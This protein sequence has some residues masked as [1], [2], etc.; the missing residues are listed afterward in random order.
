[1]E[2]RDENKGYVK[3]IETLRCLYSFAEKNVPGFNG[4]IHRGK[5]NLEDC[6]RENGFEA[7]L[8]RFVE[9][10]SHGLEQ[11]IGKKYAEAFETERR[12]REHAC[13]SCYKTLEHEARVYGYL[14][15]D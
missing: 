14:R 8:E 1:M 15:D 10:Y 3:D 12:R 13:A 4:D 9:N 11:A 5:P 6:L 7:E 2:N